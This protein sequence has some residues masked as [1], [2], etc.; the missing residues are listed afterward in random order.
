VLAAGAVIVAYLDYRSR[1]KRE[2][3]FSVVEQLNFF[4]TEILNTSNSIFNKVKKKER[5][6]DFSTLSIK[7][8]LSTF[9]FVAEYV[10]Y[11]AVFERQQKLEEIEGVE[12]KIY[13]LANQ[14]EEFSWKVILSETQN[15][16]ALSVVRGSYIDLV[17]RNAWHIL[18]SRF[19]DEKRFEGVY[20]L[21]QLWAKKIS[22]ETY[23]E[24]ITRAQKA[25]EEYVEQ[26]GE[27]PN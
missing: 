1:K 9:E 11:K 4:R 19:D 16:P 18:F 24:K 7:E 22:R 6:F 21:Y 25:A 8:A 5:D 20:Q 23:A 2:D 17:E 27:R 14:L 13:E 10:H 15:E 12:E 3:I 26:G